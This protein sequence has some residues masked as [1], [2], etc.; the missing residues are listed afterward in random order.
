MSAGE[1][2]S[3]FSKVA[4]QQTAPLLQRYCFTVIFQV[5]CEYIFNLL[6]VVVFWRTLLN[7]Y[8]QSVADA[9]TKKVVWKSVL[10]KVAY[11]VLFLFFGKSIL[12]YVSFWF[13]KLGI[14]KALYISDGCCTEFNIYCF[15]SL[16]R[17]NIYN[18]IGWEERSIGRI[19][20]LFSIFVPRSIITIITIY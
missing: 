17:K 19:C 6:G 9:Q 4:G 7:G 15:L 13:L 1:F 8:F 14:A 20:T 2:V 3:L 10:R 16:T 12:H 11:F 18:M 5:F